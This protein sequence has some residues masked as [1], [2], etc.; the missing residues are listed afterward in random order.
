MGRPHCPIRLAT[1]ATGAACGVGLAVWGC[2][3]NREDKDSSVHRVISTHS[4]GC[5]WQLAFSDG[6]KAL[7]ANLNVESFLELPPGIRHFRSR[8]GLKHSS[9]WPNIRDIHDHR[10]G[11]FSLKSVSQPWS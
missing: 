11:T 5:L 10:F 4:V 9:P 1:G 2:R 7:L 3:S 8:D 6:S